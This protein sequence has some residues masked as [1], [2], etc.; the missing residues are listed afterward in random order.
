MQQDLL[1]H[2][3]PL[4]TEKFRWCFEGGPDFKKR[5]NGIIT[6]GAIAGIDTSLWSGF[7]AYGAPGDLDEMAALAMFDTP[8]KPSGRLGAIHDSGVSGNFWLI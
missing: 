7:R 3:R 1:L 2:L 6:P 5:A 8:R 4:V